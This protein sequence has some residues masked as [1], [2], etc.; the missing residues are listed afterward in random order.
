MEICVDSFSSVEAAVNGGAS[1]LEVCSALSAGGLTPSSAL[2]K[3]IRKNYPSMIM[4]VM[5]RPREG[6]FLL[7]VEIT[8][9]FDRPGP[10]GLIDIF[11]EVPSD[12]CDA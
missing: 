1:R 12:F 9:H 7:V 5:I 8:S 6:N 3:L 10:E 4:F 11:D 2:V